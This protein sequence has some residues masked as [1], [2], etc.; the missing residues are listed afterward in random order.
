MKRVYEKI[1]ENQINSDD[2]F[3]YYIFFNNN[4]FTIKHHF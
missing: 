1:Y 3:L 4:I 2:D